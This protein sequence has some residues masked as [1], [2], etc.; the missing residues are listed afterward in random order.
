MCRPQ[1]RFEAIAIYAVGGGRTFRGAP[2][3]LVVSRNFWHGFEYKS[4][5]FIICIV[6]SRLSVE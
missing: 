5:Y 3:T 2:V 4:L 6:K 1:N